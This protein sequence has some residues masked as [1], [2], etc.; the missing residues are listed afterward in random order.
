MD[1][2]S[3]FHRASESELQIEDR[4][5]VSRFNSLADKVTNE[6]ENLHP[7]LATRALQ[8][9]WLNDLSRRYIQIVRDRIAE[10]DDDVK[11]V[12]LV[13]Y[14]NL[15]KL[16][17]PIIPFITESIWQKLLAMK[18][19]KEESVHLS[20]WPKADV[21]KIDKKLEGAFEVAFKIIE[22]G[23]AERDKLKIGL[24]W[25]LASAK[26]T[27][28]ETLDPANYLKDI[29]ARQLNVKKI[30][31]KLGNE[32]SVELDTKITPELE[33][34]GIAREL[35]REIQAER[36]NAGLNKTDRI[37]LI[38]NSD[39]ENT[40]KLEQ[41]KEF[42]MKRTGSIQLLFEGKQLKFSKK[43]R[44]KGREYLISFIRI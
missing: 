21:K 30:E 36:K 9:F 3:P 1:R 14:V 34:E 11:Y 13:I 10:D 6:L 5:I 28:T 39:K 38:I 7:H 41:V 22:K 24:K 15:L 23:L 17:A 27:L 40:K 43:I 19:V 12:L 44:I 29:I 20:D 32:F 8:N 26:I 18:I 42:I 37:N 35:S 25:P 16:L 33:S 31:V 4:W 2:T